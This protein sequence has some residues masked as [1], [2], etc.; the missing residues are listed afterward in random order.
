MALK[1][2]IDDF[3]LNSREVLALPEEARR[4]DVFEHAFRKVHQGP[5]HV[6]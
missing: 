1:T 6:S 4:V 5:S 3:H 2:D